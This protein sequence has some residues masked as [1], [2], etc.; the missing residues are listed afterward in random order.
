MRCPIVRES[1][2]TLQRGT[3][4]RFVLDEAALLAVL[5]QVVAQGFPLT[6][7]A[8]FLAEQQGTEAHR[9]G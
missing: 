5:H 6:T 4:L 8:T 2:H 7:L 1:A 9:D 3:V